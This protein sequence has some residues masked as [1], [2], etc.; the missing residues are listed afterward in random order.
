MI[1]AGTDDGLIQVTRNGGT[2]W[3]D[4]TPAQLAPW[5]KVSI[6]EASH[7]DP[8]TAYA[9]INTL[10]LDDMRPHILRTRDGGRTW[11]DI[12]R[13]LPDGGVINVV[14]E[15]PVRRGLLFAGS[16]QAVFVSFDDGEAWQALRLN[17]PATSIRD[18]AIKD[19]DLIAGTHGRGF[20]ILD[21]ISPLRQITPDVVRA[22]A[23]LFAPPVAWR[24]RWNKNTDTPLPP[25]E[26]AAPNPPDGVVISYLLA[27]DATSPV[28][29]EI[30]DST[31]GDTVRRYSSDDPPEAPVDGRNIPDYWIRP[32][33]RLQSTAGLHRF[34]WDVRYAPPAVDRFAYPIAAVV[35]NTPRTPAGIFVL[36]GTYQVRLTVDGRSYR[37]A[38][39][40]RMDPRVKTSLADLTVQFTLSR[41]VNAVMRRLVDARSAV[42]GRLAGA[43]GDAAASL[44]RVAATLQAAYAPLPALLDTLQEA[45][46]KP[47]PSVEAAATEAVKRAEEVLARAGT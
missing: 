13:G 30:I 40:V 25:D 8:N 9:A 12:V 37:R 34:V 43:T 1:W 31:T 2:N 6:L 35:R 36:P 42:A 33:A 27:A 47:V 14:R 10:R 45:D 39:V 19:A 23:F 20:W 32:A 26:P 15:D 4:V 41:S 24:F 22:P 16:E 18:L 5:A 11:T 17:M 3:T 28:V 7:F 21:D 44:P 29:L 38:V 46:A